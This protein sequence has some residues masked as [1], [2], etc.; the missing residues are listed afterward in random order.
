MNVKVVTLS[1]EELERRDYCDSIKI[2]INDEEVAS[3]CDGEAEDN[4]L[5]R[6]FSD[7]HKVV[8]L[9]K[10]AYLAGKNGESFYIE[11]SVVD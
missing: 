1:E 6:N 3:F 8:S 9:L 10:E 5:S 2:F 7:C 11:E 4:N